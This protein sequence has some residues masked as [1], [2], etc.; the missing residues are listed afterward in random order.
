MTAIKIPPN[1]DVDLRK[2]TLSLCNSLRDLGKQLTSNSR[3]ASV[4]LCCGPG[5]DCGGVK[6][7]NAEHNHQH[8]QQR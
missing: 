7:R 8:G 3:V 2:V 1:E 4:L 5:V 6:D